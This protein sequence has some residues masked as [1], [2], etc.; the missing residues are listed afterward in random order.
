[1]DFD[2]LFP[3]LVNQGEI[4]MVEADIAGFQA[5]GELMGERLLILG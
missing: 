4:T 3:T 5:A 2:S 1:M